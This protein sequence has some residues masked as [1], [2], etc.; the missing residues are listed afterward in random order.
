[1]DSRKLDDHTALEA[2]EL[3]E[4]VTPCSELSEAET[5]PLFAPEDFSACGLGALAHGHPS[6]RDSSRQLMMD[7]L[8][9]EIEMKSRRDMARAWAR[10]W[11]HWPAGGLA[12]ALACRRRDSC[13]GASSPGSVVASEGDCTERWNQLPSGASS[14]ALD[15]TDER[16]LWGLVTF[17]ECHSR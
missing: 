17:A 16:R 10:E 13:S 9:M 2:S 7:R 14:P 6:S 12:E 1:M 3:E 4:L 11:R 5:V 15:S 8:L